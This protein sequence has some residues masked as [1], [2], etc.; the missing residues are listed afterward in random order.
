MKKNSKILLVLIYI[1]ALLICGLLIYVIPSVSGLLEKTYIAENDEIEV[2]DEISAYVI[3]NEAVYTAGN[4]CNVNRLAK[5]GEL[6]RAG[7]SVV[8]L[9]GKGKTEMSSTF[10][11]ISETLGNDAVSTET[12]AT[13]S[14]G[15]VSYRTDGYEGKLNYASISKLSETKLKEF[16]SGKTVKTAK[17][18]CAKGEPIFKITANG[19]WWLVFFTSKKEAQKYEEGENV[20][21]EIGD[22]TVKAYIDSVKKCGT[23]NYRIAICCSVFVK[24]YLTARKMDAK[25]IIESASGLVVEK[26]S[27]IEIDG[28]KGVLVKNKNS[29]KVF[30]PIDILA[31][32]ED[33]CVVSESIF[34]DAEG[35][36]VETVNVYDE[37][38]SSPSDSEIEA[39]K[40][41]NQAKKDS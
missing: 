7:T 4:A 10:S 31:E 1:A 17:G 26:E 14:A 40:K 12:G 28:V 29:D 33:E 27:I 20:S 38:I 15:Y 30:T 21:L 8:E 23:D 37:I 34:M 11:G 5:S 25:V 9:S 36:F 6:V 16:C 18:A 32:S 19:D 24:D 35:N 39:V 13:T 2:S 3:R 22:E 41:E